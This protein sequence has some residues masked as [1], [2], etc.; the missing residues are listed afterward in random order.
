MHQT[1]YRSQWHAPN[2]EPIEPG[3]IVP[4]QAPVPMNWGQDFEALR[5]QVQNQPLALHPLA[6]SPVPYPAPANPAPTYH[7]PQYAPP[8]YQAPQYGAPTYHGP[9]YG[10]YQ[11]EFKPTVIVNTAAVSRSTADN[12]GDS[13]FGFALLLVLVFPFIAIALG[14][15]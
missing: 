13:W 12:R 8:T 2:L 4:Y 5:Q 11:P 9:A 10:A 1:D 6:P 7:A 3:A 15:E 14:G